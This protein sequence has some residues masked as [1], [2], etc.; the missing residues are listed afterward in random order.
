[1][2]LSL[3]AARVTR[4]LDQIIEWRGKP[5]AIRLD[6]GPEYIGHVLKD[7]ADHHEIGLR[8][9]EPGKT[10]QNGFI[11]RCNRTVKYGWLNQHIFDSIE[12]A[13]EE[14]TK[15]LRTYNNDGPNMAIGGIMPKQKLGKGMPLP[16]TIQNL[17]RST[18][19]TLSIWGYY[20][21]C[22]LIQTLFDEAFE[23]WKAEIECELL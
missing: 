15:W 19:E 21:T 13:Q 6:N 23:M 3:P 20:S 1:V 11:E 2:D 17:N 18:P 10:Q 12:H 4:A 9:I 22:S 7:W 8:L 14:A 5:K 16:T